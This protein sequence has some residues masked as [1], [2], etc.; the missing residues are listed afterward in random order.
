MNLLGSLSVTC[1][2]CGKRVRVD[3]Y[4]AHIHSGCIAGSPSNIIVEDILEKPL[5]TPLTPV[6]VKL[7]TNLTKRSLSVS[8]D[9]VLEI[10]TGGQV[11]YDK[12]F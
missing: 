3:K 1:S 9:G 4:A 8:P 7:H 11:S 12:L 10:K 6:E 5:D 2:E